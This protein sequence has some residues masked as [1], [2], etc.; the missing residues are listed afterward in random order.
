MLGKTIISAIG[1]G[2][3]LLL[4]VSDGIEVVWLSVGERVPSEVVGRANGGN[5]G[6]NG[7][8]SL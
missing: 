5:D 8:T 4:G 2:L 6:G 1:K 3:G 7:G